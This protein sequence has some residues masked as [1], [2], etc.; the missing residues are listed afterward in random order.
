MCAPVTWVPR[1]AKEGLGS[2]SS[3]G[4]CRCGVEAT[5]HCVVGCSNG[6]AVQAGTSPQDVLAIA[7][8]RQ[9]ALPFE[10]FGSQKTPE[11]SACSA[12]LAVG[13]PRIKLGFGSATAEDSCLP[14]ESVA[15]NR[16]MRSECRDHQG[17]FDLRRSLPQHPQPFRRVLPGC[18]VAG[19]VAMVITSIEVP[20]KILD[21]RLG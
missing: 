1:R 7:L 5:A 15:A 2:T 3:T 14:P 19:H 10:S 9:H 8:Y 20:D 12:P 18:P 11:F 4:C 6:S 16:A 13:K 17:N 21:R